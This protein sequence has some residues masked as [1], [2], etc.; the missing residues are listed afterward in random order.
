M[1]ALFG[2][3][4]KEKAA[5][6]QALSAFK[7]DCSCPTASLVWRLAAFSKVKLKVPRPPEAV[8]SED[9]SFAQGKGN[10]ELRNFSETPID[11]APEQ[12]LRRF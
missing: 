5:A 10:A 11:T 2:D 3:D 1:A 6:V 12:G 7:A 9:G 8:P 4:P